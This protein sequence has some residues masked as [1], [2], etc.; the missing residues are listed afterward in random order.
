MSSGLSQV[1]SPRTIERVHSL[2][3][4]ALGWLVAK[5]YSIVLPYTMVGLRRLKMLR[6]LVEDLDARR[7]PGDIVECGTCNGGSGALLAHCAREGTMSRHTWLLD[8]FQGLPEASEADGEEA[9]DWSGFCRGSESSVLTVLG[10]LGVPDTTFTIVP[11]WFKESL[12]RVEVKEISL[13]HIDAD[14]YES[15]L[16]VLRGLFDRVAVGGYVV[17]DD[18]GYWEG[19]ARAWKEFSAERGLNLRIVDIDGTGAYL[20]VE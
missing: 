6:H 19:C 8:S 1:L 17:F 12:P 3:Q 7:V 11:G 14:W 20:R 10:K 4:R 2:R 16:D 5:P 18:Y 9:Q 15:V 13:L